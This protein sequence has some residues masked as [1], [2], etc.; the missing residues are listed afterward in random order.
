MNLLER[1]KDYWIND[2]GM[3]PVKST[4]KKEP[5]PV[6]LPPLDEATF[7]ACYDLMIDHMHGLNLAAKTAGLWKKIPPVECPVAFG[8]WFYV[9]GRTEGAVINEN[10]TFFESDDCM[11]FTEY[12]VLFD[13]LP[14]MTIY[15]GMGRTTANIIDGKDYFMKAAFGLG[16]MHFEKW[17]QFCALP[18][19]VKTVIAAIAI[20]LF[21]KRVQSSSNSSS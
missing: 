1:L 8:G 14:M 16:D 11:S 2:A 21:R 4:I 9:K 7:R 10:I 13:N 18:L 19:P 17:E 15:N 5:V 12:T 3:K 6:Q 20:A